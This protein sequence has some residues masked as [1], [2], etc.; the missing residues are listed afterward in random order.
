MLPQA[1]T[2]PAP[3]KLPPVG[4]KPLLKPPLVELPQVISPVRTC[5]SC[6]NHPSLFNGIERAFL[7]IVLNRKVNNI[8]KM[9]ILEEVHKEARL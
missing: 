4:Q 7:S 9:V 3:V 2:E 8:N 1:Q 6:L 5:T